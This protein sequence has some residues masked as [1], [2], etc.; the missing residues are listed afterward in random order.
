MEAAMGV[1]GVVD[2]WI[3]GATQMYIWRQNRVESGKI[4]WRLW[5]W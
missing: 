1:V 5:L 4:A 3:L 2:M